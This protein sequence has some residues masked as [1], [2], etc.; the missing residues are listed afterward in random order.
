[1][2]TIDPKTTTI[3]LAVAVAVVGAA[4]VGAM[5]FQAF[6]DQ[7]G[8]NGTEISNV[9]RRSG[10]RMAQIEENVDELGDDVEGL[11]DAFEDAQDTLLLMKRDIRGLTEELEE[12][13]EEQR[14]ANQE[15]LDA[16]RSLS[17]PSRPAT[18]TSPSF[19]GLQ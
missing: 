19:D 13:R 9:E 2:P 7:I 4:I 15:I 10:V 14:A 3:S 16:V 6:V 8:D 5:R 12:T 1:M 18:P 11:E 17:V